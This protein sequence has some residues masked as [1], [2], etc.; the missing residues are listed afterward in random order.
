MDPTVAVDV[1]QGPAPLAPGDQ[2][3]LASDGMHGMVPE[4][5]LAKIVASSA[6]HRELAKN[7]LDASLR[8]GGKDNV[9]VLVGGYADGSTV[10]PDTSPTEFDP[11]AP[12][13]QPR[14]PLRVPTM[15]TV[16]SVLVG[17]VGITVGLV[18]V[19]WGGANSNAFPLSNAT[20][21]GTVTR[22]RPDPMVPSPSA[23]RPRSTATARPLGGEDPPSCHTLASEEVPA[24]L[25]DPSAEF[26]CGQLAAALVWPTSSELG[27]DPA[28]LAAWEA[29]LRVINT[30]WKDQEHPCLALPDAMA[31]DRL[32][33]LP[34]RALLRR[35]LLKYCEQDTTN[36]TCTGPLK[37]SLDDFRR[38]CESTGT[39]WD[40]CTIAFKRGEAGD[41][42][43]VDTQ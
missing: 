9:T 3:I 35:E 7:L 25:W 27:T 16:V 28:M 20:A 4:R 37:P 23:P 42:P 15:V 5:A 6:L 34:S 43:P 21:T 22:V 36:S 2:L 11:V 39:S 17:V 12:R 40:E 31:K 26:S 14:I 38:R 13:R 33:H 30:R 10:V 18:L 32:I 1:E 41:H 19:L 29:A 8:A 24:C